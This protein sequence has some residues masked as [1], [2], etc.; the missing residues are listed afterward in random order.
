MKKEK[1][2][3]EAAL[4]LRL[5]KEN[6]NEEIGQSDSIANQEVLLCAYVKKH[7]EIHIRYIFKDDGWSGVNFDRPG[8]QKMMQ[9]IYDG[10]INC[11]IVKDLSRLGRNHTETGKYISRVFPAFDVRFIAVNDNVDTYYQNDDLDNII[12]PFKDLLNDSYSRDI[13]IKIPSFFTIL[14]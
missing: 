8:F 13:S 6:L 14:L 2:I 12:I 9:M 4:Y 7:P 1:Q 10:K 5:S 11:V 3:F